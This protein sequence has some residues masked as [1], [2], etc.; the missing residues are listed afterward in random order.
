MTFPVFFAFSAGALA[1]SLLVLIAPGA[2]YI[3]L[4]TA[5]FLCLFGVAHYFGR[6]LREYRASDV[7]G[8]DG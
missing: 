8:D 6:S 2:F 1:T 7:D 5:L 4:I 3:F